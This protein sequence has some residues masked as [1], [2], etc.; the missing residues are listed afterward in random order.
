MGGVLYKDPAGEFEIHAG[1]IYEA[2][3]TRGH[4]NLIV[5]MRCYEGWMFYA[6]GDK[7][8]KVPLHEFVRALE[9]GDLQ[10]RWPDEIDTERL[11]MCVIM[12]DAVANRRKFEE[13]LHIKA[14]EAE[15]YAAKMG[16]GI[17]H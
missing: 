2:K 14:E 16:S 3:T 4:T 5:A 8:K 1:D 7:V 9:A 11:S 6:H 15:E 10:L 13:S 17:I 12:L